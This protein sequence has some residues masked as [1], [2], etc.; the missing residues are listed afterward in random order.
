MDSEKSVHGDVIYVG[1]K[2]KCDA[3][4]TGYCIGE[5]SADIKVTHEGCIGETALAHEFIHKFNRYAG[6]RGDPQHEM[7][8]LFEDTGGEQSLEYRIES[9]Q[10]EKYCDCT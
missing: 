10:R 4:P 3:S 2:F 9:Y 1:D 5:A 7:S 6:Y 8:T